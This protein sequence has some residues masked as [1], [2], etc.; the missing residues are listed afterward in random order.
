[1]RIKIKKM[2]EGAILPSYATAHAAGFDFC[3][4]ID[5]PVTIKPGQMEAIPTGIAVEVPIGYE[6]QIRA[7]SGLAFKHRI[8]LVNSVG[9]IDA[10]FRGEVMTGLV[11]DGAEDFVVEPGMRI[12]Q[13]I[14]AQYETA[15]WEEVDELTDTDRGAGG[16]G[17]TGTK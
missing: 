12:V 4:A 11:N 9:T 16:F 17:S 1:M 7:R 10:D 2:R 6:L 5:E 15:E 8:S 14:I 13:G 3:A